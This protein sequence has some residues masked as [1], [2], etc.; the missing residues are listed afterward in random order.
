MTLHFNDVLKQYTPLIKGQIKKLRLTQDYDEYYQVAAIALWGAHQR[1]S[2]EKGDFAAY[3]KLRVRGDLISHLRKE[4]LMSE[5]FLLTDESTEHL[6]EQVQAETTDQMADFSFHPF[7][8][9]LSPRELLYVQHVLF[10]GKSRKTVAEEQGVT[11]NT[12]ASWS[13]TARR[14]LREAGQTLGDP[15]TD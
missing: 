5:R 4:S 11:I 13:K 1:F 8:Q 10:L 15:R 7:L 2:P 12:V 9:F 6:L 14:K 3:A